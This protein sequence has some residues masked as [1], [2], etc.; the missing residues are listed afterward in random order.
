MGGVIKCDFILSTK[1]QCYNC[2]FSAPSEYA[3]DPSHNQVI[4][5]GIIEGMSIISVRQSSQCL[6]AGIHNVQSIDT[7]MWFGRACSHCMIRVVPYC[8]RCMHAFYDLS[9]H[10]NT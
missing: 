6:N 7:T 1:K 5:G 4:T 10:T 2:E 3:A 9:N 8:G